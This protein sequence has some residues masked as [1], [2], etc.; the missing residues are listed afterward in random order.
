MPF[1]ILKSMRPDV[2]DGS[3]V[4]HETRTRTVATETT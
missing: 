1:K 2:N 4:K 3:A